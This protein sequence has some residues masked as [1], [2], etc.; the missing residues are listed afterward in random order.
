MKKGNLATNKHE[1]TQKISCIFVANE[2][3]ENLPDYPFEPNYVDFGEAGM[4]FVRV[5]F[6]FQIH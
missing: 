1:R 4:H 2:R 3:F 5:T 6:N